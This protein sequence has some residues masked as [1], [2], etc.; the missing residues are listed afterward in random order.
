VSRTVFYWSTVRSEASPGGSRLLAVLASPPLTTGVITRGRVALAAAA[1]DSPEWA[2][3]NLT[4][5][6]TQ[7]VLD[8]AS[9]ARDPAPWAAARDELERGLQTAAVVLLAYGTSIPNGAAREHWQ[10]QVAWVQHEIC[11]RGLPAVCWGGLPRHPSRW[12]RYRPPGLSMADSYREMLQPAV[13]PLLAVSAFSGDLEPV[14]S[15]PGKVRGGDER[16]H[17]SSA[18]H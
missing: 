12:Q 3:A 6:P 13:L 16:R 14:A 5:T 8:L 18:L 7:T 10:S 2:I 9:L 17:P 4:Q 15:E 1:M 11:R